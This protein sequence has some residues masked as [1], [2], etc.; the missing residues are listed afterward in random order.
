MVSPNPTTGSLTLE[1][2]GATPQAG[3]VQILDL[4]GRT[5]RKETLLPS[6]QEHQISIAM[7]PAGVYF[8]KVLDDGVP[9]WKQRVL[10]Q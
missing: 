7:L 9:V 10:K 4:Y 2:K 5:L 6:I 3:T 1:F 8:V